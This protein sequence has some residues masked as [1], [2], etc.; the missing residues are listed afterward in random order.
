MN[1]SNKIKIIEKYSGRS[2]FHIFNK[3][4]VGDIWEISIRLTSP[5]SRRG[6]VYS[7]DVS[8]KNIS[9]PEVPPFGASLTEMCKYLDKVVYEELG[10]G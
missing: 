1:L 7:T 9:N 8:L 6:K 4:E 5:G 2:I 10:C 3:S